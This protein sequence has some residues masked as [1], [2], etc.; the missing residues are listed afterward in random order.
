M[1]CSRLRGGNNWHVYIFIDKYQMTRE[2]V[3]AASDDDEF[4]DNNVQNYRAR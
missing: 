2:S 3:F 4:P 1:W